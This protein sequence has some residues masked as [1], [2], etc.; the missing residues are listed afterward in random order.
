MDLCLHGNL[1]Q[2]LAA[3]ESHTLSEDELR[4]VLKG[5]ADAL[6]YLQRALV[7]HRDINPASILVDAQLRVVR[8]QSFVLFRV[9]SVTYRNCRASARPNDWHRSQAHASISVV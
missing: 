4:G 1:Q 8:V 3:R 5:I 6:V 7:V 2:I 9:L